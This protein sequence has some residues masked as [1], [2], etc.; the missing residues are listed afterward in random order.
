[1][2]SR[3]HMGVSLRISHPTCSPSEI[4]RALHREPDHAGIKWDQ[5]GRPRGV[6]AAIWPANY[7]SAEFRVGETPE[8]RIAAV[9]QFLT[10]RKEQMLQLLG[11]GG[12]ADVYVFVGQDGTLAMELEP[13]ILIVLGQIGV[14]LGIEVVR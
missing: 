3:D 12:R 7:W 1:M 14:T 13:A 6:P 8:M 11:S 10:E 2:T 4:S 5:R 9:A